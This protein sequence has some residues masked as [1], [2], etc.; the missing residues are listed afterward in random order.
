MEAY[1]PVLRL[2]VEADVRLALI[3]TWALKA[4]FP[5][6]MRDYVL[7]DCDAVLEPSLE[8]VRRA[9]GTLLQA[10]WP[11]MLW[12]EPVDAQVGAERLQGKFYL[13]AERDELCLDLTYECPIGW[14]ELVAG[15]EWRNGVPLAAANHIWHLKALKAQGMGPE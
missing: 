1:L 14:G 12:G 4:Y 9:I 15:C 13:R 6:E 2:L 10:G 11:P 8:N 7:R 3:G 5:D